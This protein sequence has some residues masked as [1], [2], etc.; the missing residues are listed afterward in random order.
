MINPDKTIFDDALEHI[1]DLMYRDAYPRFKNSPMYKHV[2]EKA[3]G[4]GWV[5]TVDDENSSS[6]K[7]I[8]ISQL[9]VEILGGDMTHILW[10]QRLTYSR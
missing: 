9:D 10:S 4:R 7:K 1:Y 6:N 3:K 2:L 5:A 8:T